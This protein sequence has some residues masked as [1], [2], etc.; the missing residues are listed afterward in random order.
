MFSL[1]QTLGILLDCH[2]FAEVIKSWFITAS[3]LMTPRCIL[4]G[5]MDLSVSRFLRWP[6]IWSV[7][8][9]EWVS[10]FVFRVLGD[11]GNSAGRENL[12]KNVAE[13]IRLLHVSCH[14][15]LC[16]IFQGG[17]VSFVFLSQ[18]TYL[19]GFWH[20]SSRHWM[21]W[22]GAMFFTLSSWFQTWS[23]WNA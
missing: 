21:S 6:W 10:A 22:S 19:S 4:S 7:P 1:F 2:D 9:I 13:H 5:S 3:S 20:M 15:I 12:R 23:H 18:V 11:V 8:M 17:T 16:L 14:Q